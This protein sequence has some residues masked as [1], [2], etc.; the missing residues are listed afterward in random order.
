MN[1]KHITIA[2]DGPG[3]AGKSTVADAVAEKLGILHLD[4][5][6]MYR[7]FAFQAL[8][9]GISPDD[10][11]G[12]SELAG[13]IEMDI[14]FENGAQ[15]TIVNGKDVSDS[16]RTPEISFAAS[17]CSKAGAVRR[18]MVGMQQALAK[19]RS[20]ILDGR[21]IGT[22]VLTGATLKV[23]LTATPEERAKRRYEQLLQNGQKA[24]YRNVLADVVARD[25][26]D[27]TRAIDP[28]RPAED[29]V[30]VDST[31]F[32]QAQTVQAVLKLLEARV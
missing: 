9:E 16:I 6:A 20:M 25:H 26:Q 12:L 32:T 23:Y 13:R 10:E 3:G 15:R 8:S 31:D 18:R 19:T 4:T 14:A 11:Q 5:G 22:K 29:A 21:D 24:D 7:A 30:I 27:S 28:L 1:D 17:T 2:I